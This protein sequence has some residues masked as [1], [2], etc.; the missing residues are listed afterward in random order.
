MPYH[1][2]DRTIPLN[3]V[4]RRIE[5]ADLVPSR[6]CLR[7]DDPGAQLRRRREIGFTDAAAAARDVFAMASIHVV[8]SPVLA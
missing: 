7:E 3:A 5:S 6:A 1:L 4:R 2:D 8:S